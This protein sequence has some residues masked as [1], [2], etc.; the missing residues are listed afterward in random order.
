[1]LNDFEGNKVP[2]E[3]FPTDQE[4]TW[5]EFSKCHSSRAGVCENDG[6]N[7]SIKIMRWPNTVHK[8]YINLESDTNISY[9]KPRYFQHVQI[10][11]SGQKN[12]TKVTVFVID[13]RT[14]VNKY[15]YRGI[16]KIRDETDDHFIL[17][18]CLEQN[19][20]NNNKKPFYSK[21]YEEEHNSPYFWKQTPPVLIAST[22]ASNAASTSAETFKSTTS[23]N[24]SGLSFEGQKKVNICSK[25]TNFEE[26]TYRSRLEAKYALF[27]KTL[28]ISFTYECV[29]FNLEKGKSYTPDFYLPDLKLLIELKPC[30]PHFEEIEACEKVAALGHNIVLVFGTDFVVP[31]QSSA[32]SRHYSHRNAF[33]GMLWTYPGILQAG[34]VMWIENLDGTLSL[35]CLNKENRKKVG[36][37]KL[38]HAYSIASKA[39]CD[40]NNNLI[41]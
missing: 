9:A 15:F 27:L 24:A 6:I 39:T 32:L 41:F 4:I 31:L 40:E 12:N 26:C 37:K 18:K 19:D 20:N 25:F 7:I 8:E 16:F 2:P 28:G 1:M 3:G 13:K 36:T 11:R 23:N 33:R 35:E 29:T 22:S 5:D 38:S 34:D 14:D 17:E 21:S 10:L 30:Y